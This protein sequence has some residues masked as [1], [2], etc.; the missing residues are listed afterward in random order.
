[1]STEAE[2]LEDRDSI[3]GLLGWTCQL[4]A[5]SG[6]EQGEGSLLWGHFAACFHKRSLIAA[7][8]NVKD[9]QGV[10]GCQG[11]LSQTGELGSRSGKGPSGCGK[12]IYA[13]EY[14]SAVKNDEVSPPTGVWL[15]ER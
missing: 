6:R 14:Y 7:L 5:W 15:H 10:L 9:W 2:E 3:R 12:H 13:M 8:L 4:L 1:M 11:L